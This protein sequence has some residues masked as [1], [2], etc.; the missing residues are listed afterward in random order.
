MRALGE[1]PLRRARQGGARGVRAAAAAARPQVRRPR[2]Q[3]GRARRHPGAAS[4]GRA[5]RSARRQAARKTINGWSYPRAP[6]R[7]FRRRLSLPRRDRARRPG[8]ARAGRGDLSDVQQR[9]RRPAARRQPTA[10]AAL[11]GRRAAAGR[12]VLVAR[13]V[14]GDAGRPRLLRRQSA[15]AAT[16]SATARTGLS[17]GADGSLEIYPAARPA[18]RERGANWLPAPAG[19]MRLVL[20]AYEP[21]EA[22]LDAT[23]R[24]PA[25]RRVG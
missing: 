1:S 20:R 9:R 8:R 2:L 18:R 15:R 23:W 22:L 14:R 13:H 12:G 6:S 19:P 25:V 24:M 4:P 7:Q 5:R 16:P 11:R 17:D 21:S 10:T 3:R